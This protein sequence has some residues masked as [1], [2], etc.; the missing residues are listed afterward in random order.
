M[1]L[2]VVFRL[3]AAVARL[4]VGFIVR[5]RAPFCYL[6]VR[7]G[8]TILGHT[9]EFIGGQGGVTTMMKARSSMGRTFIEV[10]KVS[11]DLGLATFVVAAPSHELC[12]FFIMSCSMIVF[13]PPLFLVRR[14][15]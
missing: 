6:L 1:L 8:E 5:V 9:N 10:C 11:R 3:A 15:G 4:C 14:L 12:P 7:A 13:F 2:L